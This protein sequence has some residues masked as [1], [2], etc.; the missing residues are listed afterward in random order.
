VYAQRTDSLYP[1]FTY[2]DDMAGY[3]LAFL[4]RY[5]EAESSFRASESRLGHRSPGL[6]WLLA[7]QGRKAEARAVLEDIERDWSQHYV[8]PEFIACAHA[9]LGDEDAAFRWLGRGLEVHSAFATF[10][11]WWPG[12]E[13]L[14]KDPRFR[15][16][17]KTL[18]LDGPP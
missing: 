9:A 13:P 3:E 10:M 8:V 14:R 18:N 16:V 12:A 11:F 4:G 6:A 7:T 1:G 17:L 2:L 15:D 5:D